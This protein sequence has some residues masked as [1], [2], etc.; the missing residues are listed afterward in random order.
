MIK[1]TGLFLYSFVLV[2][3]TIPLIIPR[4]VEMKFGQS[5]REEGPKTH[6]LKAGTPTMGGIGIIL[7]LL[8]GYLIFIEKTPLTFALIVTT[9]GFGLVGFLDDFIKVSRKHNLGLKAYQKLMGQF[10]FAL[11]LVLFQYFYGETGASLYVPIIRQFINLGPAYIP[12]TL[13]IVLGIVNSVNLTD[14]L[15][16]LVSGTTS[17]FMIFYGT[18]LFF[19]RE[20]M[21]YGIEFYYVSSMVMGA[22]LGFLIYNRYPA[23]I[24]MGDIGSL[25]LGGLIAAY[26]VLSGTYLL[27]PIIGL[28]YFI[29]TLSVVIQVI[30]FKLTGKRVFLMSPLHHHFEKLGWTEIKVVK[31]FWFT[32]SM[33]GLLGVILVLI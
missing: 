10:I 14:G 7:A 8:T 22:C 29:E 32:A 27:F 25:T 13:I 28:I 12:I 11:I 15:D 4:L 19:L 20:Q 21:F 1:I 16:G 24:F 3:V 23:K 5:I 6:M 2:A 17:I 33:A 31:R 26:V 30:S 18:A 9:L